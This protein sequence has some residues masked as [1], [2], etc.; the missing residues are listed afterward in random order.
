VEARRRVAEERLRI[1]RELHDVVAHHIAL[2]NVQA[3][4]AAHRL[5][6]RPDQ[7]EEALAHI[8]EAGRSVLTEMQV[9]LGVLR[10]PERAV[11]PA[12]P[13][14]SMAQLDGLVDSFRSAGLVVEITTHGQTQALPGPVDLT[15]YRVIQEALTNVQK[16]GGGSGGRVEITY[17]QTA[18][19][20][21]IDN[22]CSGVEPTRGPGVDPVLPGHGILGMRE[23]AAMVGGTLQAEDVPD[24]GF[25]VHAVLPVLEGVGD[26]DPGGARGRPG[27]DPRGVPCA[28]GVRVGLDRGGGGLERA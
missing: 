2:I 16:H 10:A 23:R 18:L 14:P 27:A 11:A 9:M 1:A 7:A 4:V 15:A 19:V 13:A 12:E 24:G 26:G 25:R 8:R 17:G 28:R 5:R 3:G 6:D 21:N 20:I 22:L